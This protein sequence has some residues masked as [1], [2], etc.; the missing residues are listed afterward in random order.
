MENLDVKCA[1]A[2]REIASKSAADERLLGRALGVLEEQGVYALFLFLEAQG[3]DPGRKI[4][5]SCLD[6]LRRNPSSAPLLN[7]GDKWNALQELAK[8]LNALLFARDL[9]RQ[10]LLYAR[11]HLKAKEEQRG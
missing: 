8:D 6:F 5:Q 4:S 2:G 1:G 11:Y 10:V 7:D 3:K 9:L